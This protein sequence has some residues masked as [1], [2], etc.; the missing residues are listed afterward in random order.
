VRLPKDTAV[1]SLH[2]TSST[3]KTKLECFGGD[4]IKAAVDIAC[5]SRLNCIWHCDCQ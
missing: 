3:K 4:L 5:F 2:L 1:S